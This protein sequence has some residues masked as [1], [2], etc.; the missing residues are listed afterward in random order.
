MK[1]ISYLIVVLSLGLLISCVKKKSNSRTIDLDSHE[2]EIS[3][4]ENRMKFMTISKYS[5]GSRLKIVAADGAE[6]TVVMDSNLT[7]IKE[8]FIIKNLID[9]DQKKNLKKYI[10]IN[11]ES[12]MD[13]I[14]K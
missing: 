10:S 2:E 5:N 8:V 12:E 4:T 13:V 1:S 11:E 3:L 7:E 6:V 9:P 14:I